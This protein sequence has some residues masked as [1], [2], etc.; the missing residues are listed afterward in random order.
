MTPVVK[1]EKYNYI[2]LILN[3]TYKSLYNVCY[4]N[5]NIYVYPGTTKE[6]GQD[7]FPKSNRKI[8][9]TSKIYSLFISDCSL[10]SL[11]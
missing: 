4:D 11:Q 10:S 1:F 6:I 2:H 5:Y 9:E 8:A 3:L 7:L